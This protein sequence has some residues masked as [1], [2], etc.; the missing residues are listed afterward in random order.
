ME[1]KT[2]ILFQIRA[3]KGEGESLRQQILEFI[4]EAESKLNTKSEAQIRILE[5]IP[6][7]SERSKIVAMEITE[8]IILM[9]MA[10]PSAFLTA[11]AAYYGTKFAKYIDEKFFKN[12][13]S[14]KINGD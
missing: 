12:Y 14:K 6:R 13:K 2:E 3:S 1:E 4:G 5:Q 10:I 8:P 9:A 7:Q 11:F